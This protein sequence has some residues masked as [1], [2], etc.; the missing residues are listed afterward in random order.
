MVIVGK[1]AF[2]RSAEERLGFFLERCAGASGFEFRV[3][4]T[5]RLELFLL[6]VHMFHLQNIVGRNFT[7][8]LREGSVPPHSLRHPVACQ[9]AGWGD[10]SPTLSCICQAKVHCWIF[11][12]PSIKFC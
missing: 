3:V 12:K 11:F 9:I 10:V 5:F 8:Y 7:E 4:R 2:T 6:F 1:S